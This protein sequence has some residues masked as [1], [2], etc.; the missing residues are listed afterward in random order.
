MKVGLIRDKSEFWDTVNWHDLYAQYFSEMGVATEFIDPDKST[1]IEDALATEADAF[2]WRVWHVP[3]DLIDATQ[4]IRALEHL[5]GKRVFPNTHMLLDYDDKVAELYLIRKNGYP[6]PQTFYTRDFEEA[7][8]YAQSAPLPQ[9]SKSYDG[10]SGDNVRLFRDRRGLVSH[11]NELF[12]QGLET[13]FAGQKQQGY[14]YLQEFIPSE[15]DMKIIV[16]GDEVALAYWR[17]S[18]SGN[19]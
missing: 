6:F 1:F 11:V 19:S 12:D 8:T 15:R 5:Y 14:V 17:T 13:H 2:L 10:A 3:G 4:K 9:V 18:D 7:R 16:I